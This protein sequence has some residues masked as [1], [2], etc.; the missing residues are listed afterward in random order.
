MKAIIVAGG[1]GTR[2]RP[3]TYLKPKPLLPIWGVPIIEKQIEKLNQAGVKEI[4]I[5]VGYK[6]E[7]FE[8]HF[9][10]REG[11]TLSRELTPLGTAGAVKLA[12]PLFRDSENIIVLNADI[13]TRFDYFELISHHRLAKN[14]VTLFS[15]KVE[16]PSRFGLILTKPNSREVEAFLEKMPLEAAKTYTNDFYVNGGIYVLKSSLFSMFP[17]NTPLSFEKDVFPTLIMKNRKVC[18]L[19]YK[20]Y[21]IDIGTKSAYLQV[22]KDAIWNGL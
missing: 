1:E 2:L 18:R 7:E 6:W 5:N 14:D 21:W 16:D 9:R 3:L 15:I 19:D 13:L 10:N 20:G 11:I 22:H 12:E 17:E 4:I 8:R